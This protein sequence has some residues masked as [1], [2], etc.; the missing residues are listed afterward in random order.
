MDLEKELD[1][2]RLQIKSMAM[3]FQD[4]EAL[5]KNGN[6]SREKIEKVLVK[7]LED[8]YS[9]VEKMSNKILKKFDGQVNM[10]KLLGELGTLRVEALREIESGQIYNNMNR[11]SEAFL[12]ISNEV[13]EIVGFKK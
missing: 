5:I 11:L 6:D 7:N 13:Y 4:L 10:K 9:R 3:L 2:I 1:H 12:S 8:Y